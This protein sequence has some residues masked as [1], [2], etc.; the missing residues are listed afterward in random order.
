MLIFPKILYVLRALPIQIP[1]KIFN[2]LHSQMNNF[3]W[4][5][6]KPR[7]SM[8][9]MNRHMRMGGLGLPDLKKY[10]MAVTLDQIRHWWHDSSDKRW[11]MLE[12]GLLDGTN[13]K[14]L[15]LDP[16]TRTP[17]IR[18]LPTPISTSLKFWASLLACPS[19]RADTSQVPIPLDFVGFHIPDFS[20]TLWK[21]HG[22]AFLE[23]LYEGNRLRPYIDLKSMYDLPHT[24]AFRYL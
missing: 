2:Q 19:S 9:I 13:P 22:I 4:Q 11:V 7:L 24:E 1:N 8:S 23:C 18:T 14:A 12:K 16:V 6:H 20:V 17:N 21:E 10:H 3:I 15:L 5:N